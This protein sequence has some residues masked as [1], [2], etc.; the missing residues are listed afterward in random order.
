MTAS[1]ATNPKTTGAFSAIRARHDVEAKP[2]K[3]SIDDKVFQINGL[4]SGG[5]STLMKT[6]SRG[7]AK[8]LAAGAAEFT[9][10]INRYG[11][12]A[13]SDIRTSRI[14]PDVTQAEA[15]ELI[16]T[17]P[18]END[19]AFAAA[20]ERGRDRVAEILERPEMLSAEA[21]GE[22]L[23]LSRVAVNDRRQKHEFLGLEGAKRG[24]KYPNWQIG[25]DGK[26]FDALP[27]LFEKLG[28]SPWAVYRFLLQ[29]HAELDGRSGLEVLKEGRSERVLDVAESISRGNFA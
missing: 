14:T 20:R 17:R 19:A 1:R 6:V 4:R 21:F 28:D 29:S 8:G 11:D 5:M 2:L 27:T 13:V 24:F 22:R 12:I 23:G 9:V 15:P 25:E 10:R 7:A 18:A 3:V 26:P 16:T